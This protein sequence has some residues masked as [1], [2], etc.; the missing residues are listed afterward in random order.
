MYQD[1]EILPQYFIV[2]YEKNENQQEGKHK[3]YKKIKK[4]NNYKKKNLEN[5][6]KNL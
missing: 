3:I 5:I 4:R 6:E 2:E 1:G